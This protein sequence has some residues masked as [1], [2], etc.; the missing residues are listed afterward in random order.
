MAKELMTVATRSKLLTKSGFKNYDVCLN[1][2]VGCKF[3][4]TYC[5]VR[6]FVKDEDREWGDFVRVRAHVSEKLPKE[7]SKGYVRLDANTTIFIQ[8]ARLVI[9]TM[10]DPYQPAE[11]KYRITRSAL[12]AILADGVPRFKKVGIFTRSPLVLQDI[13]LIKR[14][15]QARVHFTITPFPAKLLRAIEPFSPTTER[16]WEVIK[17]LKA[18]GIRTHVNVSPIMPGM[19]EDLIE[20]FATK[21]AE[22]GVDEYFVDPMQPYKESF[23]AFRRAC[24]EIPELD[25]PKIEATMLVKADYLAWKEAYYKRWQDARIKV[26]HLAPNQ[27]PIWSDHER[28]VWLDMR[29]GQ[30]MVAKAYGD[31]IGV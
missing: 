5:Y 31:E 23:E 13:E 19:S 22:I 2:Y 30:Q 24:L 26:A 6:F 4:C 29:S 7:I 28:K 3:G 10:T 1:T 9:G 15:P 12:E 21:L 20:E 25:W 14:L 27:L 17:Q 18:A 11:L 16:R 8:D